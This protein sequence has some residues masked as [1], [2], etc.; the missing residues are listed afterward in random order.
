VSRNRRAA[1]GLV[2]VIGCGLLAE[3]QGGRPPEELS[4][5]QLRAAGKSPGGQIVAGEP[6]S[7]LVEAADKQT[8]IVLQLEPASIVSP[9]YVLEGKVRYEGIAIQG[10]LE[11]WSHFPDGKSFFS[12][13]LGAGVMSPLAGTSDW[14]EFRLPFFA[15]PGYL[16]LKLELNVV[17]PGGGRVWLGP[18][19]LVQ[20]D[21]ARDLGA[22]SSNFYAWWHN[23]GR[24][25]IFG[26]ILGVVSAVLVTTVCVL[27]SLGRARR[28]V[29]SL[30][31]LMIGSGVL[32]LVGGVVAYF[33]A[34]PYA[35][36]YPL[37]I[38]GFVQ[39]L[40]GILNLPGLRRRYE[41]AELRRMHAADIG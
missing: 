7:L 24:A 28:L 20:S 34:L 38:T 14:R 40:V 13:T 31:A 29:M 8:V 27:G 15:K 12:R 23:P 16:P 2:L 6:E 18:V 41:Q 4:W 21:D 26:T 9:N 5:S 36:Y 22:A 30:V 17:L 10:Y 35:V 33:A 32:F 39:L 1:W 37:V 11:M 25:W 3:E 19:K